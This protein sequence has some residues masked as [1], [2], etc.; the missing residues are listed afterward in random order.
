LI[1]SPNFLSED[2][3]EIMRCFAPET[4]RD[5]TKFTKESLMWQFG[6]LYWEILTRGHVPYDQLQVSGTFSLVF[7]KEFT[8]HF[9]ACC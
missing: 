8:Y 1:I 4:L 5:E 7:R 2:G 3:L 9:R 6:I